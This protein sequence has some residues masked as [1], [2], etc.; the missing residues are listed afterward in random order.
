MIVRNIPRCFDADIYPPSLVVDGRGPKGHCNADRSSMAP[1]SG[2][3][4][5]VS[6]MVS[7]VVTDSQI[8]GRIQKVVFRLDGCLTESRTV[9]VPVDAR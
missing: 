1:P 9:E 3:P 4:G 7:I 8:S 6:V 2:N 5:W